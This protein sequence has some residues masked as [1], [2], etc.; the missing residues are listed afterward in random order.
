MSL[1]RKDHLIFG[2]Y[3]LNEENLDKALE[4]GIIEEKF[5][6]LGSSIEWADWIVL[7]IPVDGIKG[8][9][10]KVMDQIDHTKAVI[11]FGSTKGT[12]CE[13]VAQHPKR[14]RFIAAHPIAGT[15]HSGPEAAFDSLYDNMNLI[16]CEGEL[17]DVQL[18]KEFEEVAQMSGFKIIKMPADEHDRHLAY[19]SH[20][21]HIT[22]YALSNTVLKKEKDGE[23]ILELAGSGFASTVRLAKS[24]PDMWTSIFLENKQ[25]VLEGIENYL[26][27]LKDLKSYIEKSSEEEIKAYLTEGRVIRK[28]LK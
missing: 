11:D 12:I 15:E 8:L 21:S 3:D 20:L 14:S 26:Q 5:L 1:K 22:S 10:P 6:D 4:L 2:G 23:V 13:M 19:I 17:V 16:I 25:M 18:L 27:D 28:I 7:A 9:L 24:S